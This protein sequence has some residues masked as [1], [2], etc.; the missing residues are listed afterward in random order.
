[1]LMMFGRKEFRF[2]Q[3]YWEFPIIPDRVGT[4][5]PRIF[6]WKVNWKG[7]E[8]TLTLREVSK[9]DSIAQPACWWCSGGQNSDS[10]NSVS[11]RSSLT[12]SELCPPGYFIKKLIE[13][14][15]RNTNSAGIKEVRK[16]DSIVQTASW[17]FREDRIP[18]LSIVWVPDHPWQ[19]RN[20]VPPDISLLSWLSETGESLTLQ[21]V[22]KFDFFAQ[23]AC[24]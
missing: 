20:S 10:V 2:C 11:S 3:K 14:N 9:S 7:T 6:R 8:E 4:L 24:W 22:R 16:S 17:W 19:S 13:K 1:M 5:S 18:I 12:D 15:R 23:P 21:E